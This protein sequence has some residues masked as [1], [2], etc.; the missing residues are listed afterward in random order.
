MISPEARRIVD[1]AGIHAALEV[2]A[3]QLEVGRLPE[4]A[5][6]LVHFAGGQVSF[7]ELDEWI[8]GYSQR[9]ATRNRRAYGLSWTS[10]IVAIIAL[11]VSAGSLAVAIG[12]FPTLPTKH[13]VLPPQPPAHAPSPQPAPAQPNLVPGLR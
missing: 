13:E 9:E 3:K 1:Q 11:L 2:Y 7:G 4:D 12:Y 8:Q 6:V 10:I 5:D